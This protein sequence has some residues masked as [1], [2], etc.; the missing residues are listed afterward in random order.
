L[1]LYDLSQDIGEAK[2]VQAENPAVVARL[3]A[4][5]GS[6]ISDGRSTPGAQQAN[7]AAVRFPPAPAR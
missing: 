6:Y 3:T 1:Q 5:L 4:L 7:D 2:N